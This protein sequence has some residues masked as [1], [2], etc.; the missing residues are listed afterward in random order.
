MIGPDEGIDVINKPLRRAPAAPRAAR[1]GDLVSGSFTA[2]PRAARCCR[3]AHL[4]GERVPV[5]ARVSNGGG[6]PTVPDYAPDVRGL[7]VSFELPD[8]S[9]T[10]LVAQSA[11]RFFSPTSDDFFD[12][13]KREHGPQ[14]G[15]GACRS[16]SRRTRWRCGSL[17]A[18]VPSLRPPESYATS[19]Y[20][21]VHAY[22]WTARR[23]QH[24][25]HALALDPGGRRAPHR[26]ARRAQPRPRL[27]PGGDRRAP[28]RR[29]R[30]LDARGADRRARA[31]TSTIRRASGPPSAS[32][33]SSGRSSSTRSR[34]T[35]RPTAGIVV[36]DPTRVTD[37]IELSGD[38]V[39]QLPRRGLLGV[40]R[41]PPVLS[42]AA[43]PR[44]A[45]LVASRAHVLRRRRRPL[46]PRRQD[47]RDHRLRL[48]GPRPRAEPPRL[49]RQRRR[50][51]ARGLAERRRGARRRPR[52]RCPSPRRRAAATS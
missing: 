40:G 27:P 35:P 20:F 39:L 6:D 51:P 21:T 4:S 49:G 12:L 14:L 7:A 28:R 52:G 2:T 30:A 32:A 17:P 10:D 19:R 15:A 47:R 24:E 36:F 50:R 26:P 11:P 9:R 48:P 22:R 16:I 8:G 23:R 29:H 34:P 5:L 37:G 38:Q 1:E 18:N 3:A 46:A 42:A 45:P 43:P 31:T 33:S 13:V 44:G 41:A 25:V